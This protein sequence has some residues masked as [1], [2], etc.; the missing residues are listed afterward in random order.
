MKKK[1][2]AVV[3]FVA[4]A[5]LALPGINLVTG[6]PHGTPITT[7]ASPELAK[8]GLV[9]EASCVNCHSEEHVLPWYANLPPASTVIE[10]DIH[11]GLRRLDLVGAMKAPDGLPSEAGLAMVE[12]VV[13]QGV[14]PPSRYVAL[15]W[16]ASL[17]AS[18]REAVLDWVHDVRTRHF[19]PAGLAPE[20]ARATVH[21]LPEKVEYDAAKA[22]LGRKLYHDT[23]LSGDDTV[24]CASC[25]DLAKGGTDQ[26]NVSTGIRG[27][28]GGINAP[29]TFNAVFNVAQFWDGRAADLQAQA[30]GPPLN[31]VEMGGKWEEITAKL[32]AD[33]AFMAEFTPVYPAGPTEE[34]ITD[35]IA[36][37]E[38]TLVT[39]DAFDRF[40]R[41][42]AAALSADAKQG[43]HEFQALGCDTCHVGKALGGRSYEIM[44]VEEDYFATRGTQPTD[45]DKGR[46][47][48]TKAERDVHRF[49]V[50]I[51][52]NVALTHPYFHDA[53]A[54]DLPAA[55]KTMARVQHG[56]TLTE[57]Q[58]KALV[59]FLES[60]TGTWEGRQL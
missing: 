41:G 27:Q 1:I 20:V 54:P 24:S 18:E 22:A 12:R 40:L 26:A 15:H 14:M 43:W 2:V 30:G 31:P 53:S 50:P 11:G 25:H 4:L 39:P 5:A 10:A 23:R 33:P 51:L 19:A 47:S 6:S 7:G 16:D 29:T 57:P 36:E 59:A 48:V 38:R 44:G 3:A 42:D 46:A 52:R 13:D 9:L 21:P 60:L 58:V 49:K 8:A 28:A 45:A 35:A 32:A 56:V 37:F 17:S 55:V 34:T